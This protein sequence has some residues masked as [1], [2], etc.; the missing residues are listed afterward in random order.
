MRFQFHLTV[1]LL[2]LSL[3]WSPLWSDEPS[4]SQKQLKQR[5]SPKL[6]R[7]VMAIQDHQAAHPDPNLPTVTEIQQLAE[8]LKKN[9]D[10]E[11]SSLLHRFT[12]EYGSLIKVASRRPVVSRGKLVLHVKAYELNGLEITPATIN[13]GQAVGDAEDLYAELDQLVA[14]NKV[15]VFTEPGLFETN[16]GQPSHC[17]SDG[18]FLLPAQNEQ[19]TVVKLHEFNATFEFVPSIIAKQRVRLQTTCEFVDSAPASQSVTGLTSTEKQAQRIQSVNELAL[20]EAAVHF[21]HCHRTGRNFVAIMEVT[22]RR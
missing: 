9:G 6:L 13:H 3:V 5:V 7:E 19:S 1:A 22:P 12:S 16:A 8:K 15:K 4:N 14:A 17:F 2:I 18:E 11:G 20:G 10:E 21:Y